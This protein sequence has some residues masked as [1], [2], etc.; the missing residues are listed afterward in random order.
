MLDIT[1]IGV[2]M[3][4][5]LLLIILLTITTHSQVSDFSCPRPFRFTE[6][7][8]N[9]ASVTEYFKKNPHATI[10][11]GRIYESTL[12]PYEDRERYKWFDNIVKQSVKL[13]Y[14][15]SL[16]IAIENAYSFTGYIWSKDGGE[17]IEKIHLSIYEEYPVFFD[18]PRKEL[19]YHKNYM[20][21][22][23]ERIIGVGAENSICNFLKGPSKLAEADLF[24]KMQAKN[25][26]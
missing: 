14:E 7:D 13:K 9:L 19:H 5:K 6:T 21:I 25:A 11:T 24:V 12:G 3:F 8:F 16:N 2:I 1:D 4:K 20:F 22:A 10:L 15:I 18:L 26:P 17:Y 23:H